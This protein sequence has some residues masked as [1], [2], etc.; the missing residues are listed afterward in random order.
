[1]GWRGG[2]PEMWGGVIS[3]YL[4]I[5]S[6]VSPAVQPC[7]EALGRRIGWRAYVVASATRIQLLTEQREDT[8]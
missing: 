4:T 3:D 5:N 1:M 7:P 8:P 2:A 6:F